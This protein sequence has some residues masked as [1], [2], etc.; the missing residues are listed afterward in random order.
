MR[1]RT[2]APLLALLI[3]T[4]CGVPSAV[5]RSAPDDLQATAAWDSYRLAAEGT[6]TASAQEAEFLA[7]SIAA[8]AQVATTEAGYAAATFSA[9]S[10]RTAIE[11]TAT[12]QAY[13][14]TATIAAAQATNT[15]QAVQVTATFQSGQA[16]STAIAQATQDSIQTTA[17]A[18]S[19]F[20]TATTQFAA[21]ERETLRLERDKALQPLKTYGPWVLGV[22]L[23]I[24][25]AALGSWAIL[26]AVRAWDARQRLVPTGP[27]GRTLFIQDGPKGQR[28]ILDPARM[29]GP[30]VEMRPQGTTMPQLTAPELQNMTTARSQAVELRQAFHPP[31]PI[32]MQP[33]RNAGHIRQ[34][35]APTT[36]PVR[37][38]SAFQLPVDPALP[39]PDAPWSLFSSWQGNGIPLGMSATGLLTINPEAYPHWLMAGMTGSGKTRY[40]LR[41]LITSAL[42]AGWQ[43]I[44]YDRSGLDFLPFQD[45]PNAYTVLLPDAQEAIGHLVVLYEVILQRLAYLRQHRASTWGHLLSPTPTGQSHPPRLMAVVEEFA[46]L[47]D[48]L[49]GKQKEAL[50]RGARMI[51]AEGRKAGVHLALA[52]QDPTHRSIDL[53]IRRNTTSVAF[54]VKDPDASRVVLSTDGAEKLHDRQFLVVLDKLVRGVAFAPSDA[55]IQQ[56]LASRPVLAQPVPAWLRETVSATGS[57]DTPMPVLAQ[58]PFVAPVPRKVVFPGSKPGQNHQNHSEHRDRLGTVLVPGLVQTPEP[59]LPLPPHRPPTAVEKVHMRRLYQQGLSRNRVCH[60]VYGFKNGKVYGWVNEAL[61]ELGE[62]DEEEAE[63]IEHIIA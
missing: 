44:I 57:E 45:H 53:R 8:T 7:R 52:L 55:E 47:S 61:A 22:A 3:L 23:T 58:P 21:A 46:N 54:R 60:L 62:E 24:L 35:P 1:T 4:A 36:A 37:D 10:T 18:Q 19:A 17:T 43:V 20:A 33:N 2:L 51:A 39:P 27:F 5:P 13:Q 34:L 59:T 16:T 14:A 49:D 25:I 63:P 6:Q 40:G 50:W 26:I 12:S 29:F 32:V 42:A 28:T 38:Q 31:Y 48:A 41:P 15:A 11:A 30:V 56:F 9:Q